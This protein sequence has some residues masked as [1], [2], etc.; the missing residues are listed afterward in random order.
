M[1]FGIPGP[2]VI[3]QWER[4][5]QNQGAEGLRRK[6]QRRRPAMS[7]SKTKKVKLKTT[8]HEELLK[9]LEYLRAENAYLKKLQA[10][11]EERIVRESGK[12]PKP[13]KD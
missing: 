8:P 7:K 9:E 10:L 11:V 6:P 4:L 2:F 1:H 13:S 3:R 12:E 5:Y